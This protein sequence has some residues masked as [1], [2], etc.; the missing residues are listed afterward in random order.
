[1]NNIIVLVGLFIRQMLQSGNIT[2]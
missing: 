2:D 1:M